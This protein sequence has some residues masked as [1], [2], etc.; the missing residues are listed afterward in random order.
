[1]N[2]DDKFYCYSFNLMGKFHEQGI[3]PLRYG[4]NKHSGHTYAIY[5]KTEQT[6]RILREWAQN[7]PKT[8]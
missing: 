1:M 5:D 6:D 8:V 3:E 2:T 7:K 4:Y